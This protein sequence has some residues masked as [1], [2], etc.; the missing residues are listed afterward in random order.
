MTARP[1]PPPWS[2]EELEACFV[3]IDRGG[4][5]LAFVYFEE[6]VDESSIISQADRIIPVSLT[7]NYED[8]YSV[9]FPRPC[10]EL[11]GKQ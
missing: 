8:E 3:V 4:Q 10:F 9:R 5:K 2:V 6:R 1:F 11:D 7:D